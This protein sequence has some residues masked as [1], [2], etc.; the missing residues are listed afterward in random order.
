MNQLNIAAMNPGAIPPGAGVPMINNGSA[1]PRGDGTMNNISEAMVN[2]LN[3]HIYD[4]FLKRGYFECARALV[5]D[6]SI[7]LNTDVKASPSQ[8]RDGDMNGVEGDAMM[9]DG[10]DG[11]KLNIPDDLPRPNLASE[12]QQSSFL[13]DWF[14]LFWDFFWAQR[15]RGNSNDAKQY[16]AHTQVLLYSTLPPVEPDTIL[17]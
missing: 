4:Y 15:K 3:T 14:S 11:D 10:K 5:R 1:A 8:R 12:S 17:T 16:L 7:K 6:E 9:T 2:N 13:L